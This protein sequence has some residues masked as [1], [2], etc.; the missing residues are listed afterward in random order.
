ML[1]KATNALNSK[2]FSSNAVTPKNCK[3]DFFKL[4]LVQLRMCSY[5]LLKN[6]QS[7]YFIKFL[8]YSLTFDCE[9]SKCS[10][11]SQEF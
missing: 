11:K 10:Y 4:H 3:E 5:H 7:D 2:D 8:Y 1:S 9:F 6:P